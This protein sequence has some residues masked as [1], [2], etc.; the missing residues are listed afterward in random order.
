MHD[1]ASKYCKAFFDVYLP[2]AKGLKI[3]EIGSLD[4]SG[5]IRALAP[6]DNAYLGLDFAPGKGVDVIV[7]DP[8]AMP[9]EDASADVV[10]TSSCFEHSEF[11]WLVF[12]DAMRILKPGGL[13]YIN[14]PS[15]GAFHRHPVD[16]W[17]F[18]PDSGLALQNWGRRKGIDVALL[19]SFIGRQGIDRWN[20][21]VGVFVKGAEY[22]SRFPDRIQDQVNFRHGRRFGSDE[23]RRSVRW[24][25]DQ[26]MLSWQYVVWALGNIVRSRIIKPL[27]GL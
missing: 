22:A 8:Y 13:L 1:T 7:Q 26:P 2:H 17:R 25:Q 5:S 19:E 15:N 4:V 23:V 21:F 10:L 18:Y 11:F 20:D 27:L 3:V 16:C 6:P 12:E 9:V 14:V 24:P